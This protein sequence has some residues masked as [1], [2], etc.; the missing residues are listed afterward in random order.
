M[1]ELITA[2]IKLLE[3]LF[4]IGLAGSAVVLLLTIVEDIVLMLEKDDPAELAK[5]E[6]AGE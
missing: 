1:R 2:L 3:W 6:Q 5:P 4:L